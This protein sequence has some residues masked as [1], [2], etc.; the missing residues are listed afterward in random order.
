M[1][2]PRAAPRSYTRSNLGK[3]ARG[4][5]P[6][7]PPSG[8]LREAIMGKITRPFDEMTADPPLSIAAKRAACRYSSTLG[9]FRGLDAWP[10]EAITPLSDDPIVK[11]LAVATA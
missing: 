10:L 8:Q 1:L 3:D 6:R 4:S 5:N 2:T 11:L 7:G 9:I